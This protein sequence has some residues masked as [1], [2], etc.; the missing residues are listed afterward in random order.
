MTMKTN[1]NK[2]YMKTKKK[3]KKENPKFIKNL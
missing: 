3:I 2:K 1:V